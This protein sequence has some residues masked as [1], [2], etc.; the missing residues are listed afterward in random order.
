MHETVL[1]TNTPTK[2][3]VIQKF[4]FTVVTIHITVK[5]D[6]DLLQNSWAL[7]KR[8]MLT[9]YAVNLWHITE[10]CGASFTPVIASAAF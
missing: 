6:G 8:S 9:A 5:V 4:S 2:C 7:G 3:L 10:M 1:I